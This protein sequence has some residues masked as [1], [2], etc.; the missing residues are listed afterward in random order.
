MNP[1][2]QNGEA[3]PLISLGSGFRP[4]VW[5]VRHLYAAIFTLGQLARSPLSTVTTSAVIGIALALPAGLYVLLDNFN[6]VSQNWNGDAQISL[7]L[8]DSIGDQAAAALAH[9]LAQRAEIARVEHITKDQALEEYLRLTGFDELG[10]AFGAENPLP[11]VLIAYPTPDHAAPAEMKRLVTALSKR[12]EVDIVQSDLEWL[13]RLHATVDI[14]RRGILILAGL[15]ALGVLLIIGNTIRLG[16]QNCHAEIEVAKLVGA[17]DAFVRRPFLYNGLWHGILGALLAWA[18]IS[19]SL[20]LLQ[21]PIDHLGLLYRS[22]FRLR[23]PDG[24]SIVSLVCGG[25][26]LGLIGAWVAVARHLRAF[27]PT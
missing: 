22:D 20:S 27:E 5:V 13:Q 25:A 3:E 16:I 8:E 4:R 26:L 18:L 2:A 6:A 24:L 19:V 7:Y 9:Q 1:A 10:D 11:P 15:L 17:T 21:P 12:D 23:G 14:L